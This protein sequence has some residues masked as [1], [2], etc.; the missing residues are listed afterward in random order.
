MC[1]LRLLIITGPLTAV[2]KLSSVEKR[3]SV[4]EHWT[5]CNGFTTHGCEITAHE[6]LGN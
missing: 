4:E 5:V 2:P 3:S 6:E 1:C